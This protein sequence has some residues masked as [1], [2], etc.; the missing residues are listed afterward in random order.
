MILSINQDEFLRKCIFILENT[1]NEIPDFLFTR[2]GLE[3][4]Y[5]GEYAIHKINLLLTLPLLI[6][7]KLMLPEVIW[8]CLSSN[9]VS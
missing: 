3:H 8:S 9:E 2:E 4:K 5:T 1:A 6:T 7:S